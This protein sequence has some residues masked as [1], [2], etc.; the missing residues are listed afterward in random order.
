MIRK[1]PENKHSLTTGIKRCTRCDESKALSEYHH[2]ASALSK[3][4]PHCKKCSSEIQ[5][6]RSSDPQ[7]VARRKHTDAQRNASKEGKEKRRNRLESEE[8]RRKAREWDAK[9]HA[10]IQVKIANR[11]RGRIGKAV[12]SKNKQG[13]AVF[14]LGC[15][16]EFFIAH[17][18]GQ[19]K[20]GMCW[21]NYGICGWHLDHIQPLSKFDLTDREQVLD[22]FNYRNYQPLWAADNIRKHNK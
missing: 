14:D 16:I 1:H 11:L 7:Q 4:Q 5:K 3:R 18:E 2:C 22:A 15:S 6:I 10:N 8:G 12:F 21:D 17:I 20:D 13:S 19:F 9:Y